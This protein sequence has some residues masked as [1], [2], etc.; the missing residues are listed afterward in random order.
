MVCFVHVL[1]VVTFV[2]HKPYFC[3]ACITPNL[4]QLIALVNSKE[5]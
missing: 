1:L 2:C 3:F 5:A 4:S